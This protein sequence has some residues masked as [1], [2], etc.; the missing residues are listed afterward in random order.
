MLRS[1]VVVGS[2]VQPMMWYA[3][4]A[5]G[6]GLRFCA[7]YN[8]ISNCDVSYLSKIITGEGRALPSPLSPLPPRLPTARQKG[9][10]ERENTQNSNLIDKEARKT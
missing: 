3:A 5:P 1:R 9:G 10:G 7:V 2:P 4:R 6:Q 8:I